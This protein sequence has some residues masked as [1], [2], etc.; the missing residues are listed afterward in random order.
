MGSNLARVSL[1]KEKDAKICQQL[2]EERGDPEKEGQR[3][4]LLVDRSSFRYARIEKMVRYGVLR[5]F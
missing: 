2:S 3:R 4:V 5:G 1:V